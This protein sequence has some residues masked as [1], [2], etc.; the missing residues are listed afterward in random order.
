MKPKKLVA[1]LSLAVLLLSSCT[2][3]EGAS[4][5][6]ESPAAT[7]EP[8]A[9]P[10]S[11]ET[12]AGLTVLPMGDPMA[13][14][15]DSLS[16]SVEPDI[17]SDY[18]AYTR[19]LKENF[20]AAYLEKLSSYF[21]DMEIDDMSYGGNMLG[22]GMTGW[23]IFT[24]T[25]SPDSGIE[26]REQY[27][28]SFN[29]RSENEGRTLI[30]FQRSWPMEPVDYLSQY[31]SYDGPMADSD[32]M[33]DAYR[34]K[35]VS[36][37]VEAELYV[38]QLDSRYILTDP[39]KLEA[40]ALSLSENDISS[41]ADPASV[42]DYNPLYLRFEDGSS[43]LVLTAADGSNRCYAWGIWY[44]YM[45]S[46]S[47]FQRFSVPLEAEGYEALPGGG[48]V[49][50]I[51]STYRQQDELTHTLEY[52]NGDAPVRFLFQQMMPTASGSRSTDIL[53]LYEYDTQ[54]RRTK[55]E[56][57]EDGKLLTTIVYEYS[58]ELLVRMEESSPTGGGYY[59]TYTYDELG[60]LIEQNSYY[61]NAIGG[62]ISRSTA[63]WYDDQGYRH[64]YKE[65]G[66]GNLVG[67]EDQPIRRPQD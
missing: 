12:P 35:E 61:S 5:A 10:Q 27:C 54:G 16:F 6:P 62:P 1:L 63:Y 25:P 19:S 17:N 51:H 57:M 24:G 3:G 31:P 7:A 65:D 41:S 21:A 59:E 9:V 46:E 43:R 26:P 22:S 29:I 50:T 11:Q 33:F 8:A 32:V 60:R 30:E 52:S 23:F 15:D 58:G 44:A 34:E 48:T 49:T 39:E 64:N 37:L 13:G 14:I 66:N 4:P 55:E 20:K 28:R 18:E 56:H 2:S 47:I 67:Y 42:Y 45:D 36:G 53:R 38:R 40:L